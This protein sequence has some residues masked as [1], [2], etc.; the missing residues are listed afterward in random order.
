MSRNSCLVMTV[1]VLLLCRVAAHAQ[2]GTGGGSE[3]PPLRLGGLALTP[4]L[5]FENA[6]YD[7]NVFRRRRAEGDWRTTLTPEVSAKW[8]LGPVRFA[9][10]GDLRFV[11]FQRFETERSVDT[12]DRIAVDW[13]LGPTRLSAGYTLRNARERIDDDLDERARRVDHSA[14]FGVERRLGARTSAGLTLREERVNFAA[15]AITS[16]DTSLREVLAR[17]VQ[18]VGASARYAAT[19]RS[20]IAISTEQERARF[21]TSPLRDSSGL[22]V[23]PQVKFAST[24]PLRGQAS[25]GYGRFDITDPYVRDFS[26]LLASMDVR[27]VLAD[28]TRVGVSGGRDLA[29]SSRFNEPYYLR[30]VVRA[31][32]T[33]RVGRSW[34]VAAGVGRRWNHYRQRSGLG[35]ATEPPESTEEVLAF[36]ASLSRK[37]TRATRL[38]IGGAHESRRSGLNSN[39]NYDRL[40]ISALLR[41]AF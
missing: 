32:V 13:S 18:I 9:A 26:G 15:D 5:T 10:E 28:S 25:V 1:G 31:S 11:Y 35:S 7:S 2:S 27:Y 38:E 29:Y 20:S 23:M 34:D 8:R 40:Q 16:S 24:G 39:R 37:I 41:H 30:S 33:H 17:S 21:D 22:R 6:G 36:D 12:H 4:V 14:R 19:P 3:Q